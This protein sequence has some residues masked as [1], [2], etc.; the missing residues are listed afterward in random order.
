MMRSIYERL[1]S[2]ESSDGWGGAVSYA[3]SKIYDSLSYGGKWFFAD[4]LS[5]NDSTQPLDLKDDFES[6]D[7][8]QI[9]DFYCSFQ[10]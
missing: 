1:V 7:V 10:E 5:Y 8:S 9:A 3:Q 6:W 4:D 2:I